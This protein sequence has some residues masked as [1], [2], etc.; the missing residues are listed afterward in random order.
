M[1]A[2]KHPNFLHLSLKMAGGRLVGQRFVSNTG[3]AIMALGAAISLLSRTVAIEDLGTFEWY[4]VLTVGLTLIMLGAAIFLGVRR[5]AK[6]PGDRRSFLAVELGSAVLIFFGLV[7]LIYTSPMV[8]E[9]LGG[10]RGFW[11]GIAGSALV[12]L[13]LLVAKVMAINRLSRG[14]LRRLSVC[15]LACATA[16]ATEGV[17]LLGFAG[18]LTWKGISVGVGYVVL[19]GFQLMLLGLVIAI[20][21]FLD[22][23]KPK[24]EW[25]DWMAFLAISLVALEGLMVV[26]LADVIS[27]GPYTCPMG[28]VV[29]C[30]A[31]LSALSAST[32][33]CLAF[34]PLGS[35]RIQGRAY[36]ASI[37]IIISIPILAVLMHV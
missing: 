37:L 7:M 14:N 28:F 35:A 31:Q 1:H 13:G 33:F 22:A 30:G 34:S 10:L 20:P 17:A 18:D 27:L 8:L 36:L 3:L 6:D 11:L 25:L 9:G 26:A 21:P 5:Y 19:I 29:L 16:I 24:W 12:F 23:L 15:Y 2:F 32:M 4:W